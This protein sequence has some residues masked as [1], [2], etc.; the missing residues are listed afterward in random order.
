MD[1]STHEMWI[2]F[3][4]HL[5]R[6]ELFNAEQLLGVVEKPWKWEPE[7]NDFLIRQ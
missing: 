6:E 1:P 7:F 4:T 3:L 5:V 2:D